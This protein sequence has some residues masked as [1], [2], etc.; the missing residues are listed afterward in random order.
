M[1]A[2]NTADS[3]SIIEILEHVSSYIKLKSPFAPTLRSILES[4]GGTAL[5]THTIEPISLPTWHYLPHFPHPVPQQPNNQTDSDYTT[6]T[7]F[8]IEDLPFEETN[9]YPNQ[10]PNAF[11]P[12]LYLINNPDPVDP[13]LPYTF[14]T[15]DPEM[16]VTHGP[17]IRTQRQPRYRINDPR[18]QN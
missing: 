10:A 7:H 3:P 1:L 13:E 9:P 18:N 12:A 11:I 14:K 15:F 4:V 2:Y 6:L 8:M 16:D 5:L 17:A